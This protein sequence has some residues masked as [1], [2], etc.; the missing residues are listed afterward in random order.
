MHITG[1]GEMEKLSGIQKNLLELYKLKWDKE[2]LDFGEL[3]RRLYV[4]EKKSMRAISKELNVSP[5]SVNI[6]LREQ[7]IA[8]RQM[9]WR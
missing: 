3:M 5:R 9:Y 6:W 2:E 8:S 4:E 1:G 7:G